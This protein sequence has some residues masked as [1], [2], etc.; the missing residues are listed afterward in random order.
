MNTPQPL[1]QPERGARRYLRLRYFISMPH[2]ALFTLGALQTVLVMLW[3]LA[4]LGGR[5]GGWYTAPQWSVPAPW[6]HLYLMIF[7]VFPLFMFGFLMT[8][9]PKWMAGAPV[10][11]RHYLTAAALLAG[12]IP[13]T[14]IGLLTTKVI[15]LLALAL[16]LAGW[17]LALTALLRVYFGAQRPDT[18][19]TL[20]TSGGLAL[21]LLLLLAYAIGIYLE[22]A[23]W[24]AIAR[25][26]GVWWFLLPVFFAVSHRLIPFFSSVVLPDYP[27][28]RPNWA[29]WLVCAGSLTHGVLELADLSAWT[30]L[31]DLP[32]AATAGYLTWAWLLRQSL[33]ARILAMLHLSFA[34]I[35]IALV[36]YGIHS[37]MLLAGTGYALGRGPLHALLIGYFASLLVA[38]STRVSLG[39]SGRSLTADQMA[40]G[41][42]LSLQAVAVLRAVA[43]FPLVS[44]YAAP[45]YLLS[46]M[47]WLAAFII[48]GIRFLPLYWR[49]ENT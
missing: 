26:G 18:T 40:W 30:W 23:S 45:L 4:D 42:F 8:T 17:A 35:T 34:W 7:L 24:I 1:Q 13:L 39:H 27:L 3:W 25:I 20:V 6:A 38:M 19:H 10:A 29:L 46:A 36:L 44:A 37:L 15:F 32:M 12:A 49:S 16:H 43:D 41:I 48:W 47:L 33:R 31:V 9:Y 5:Y 21:G 14:Y 22:D 28:V 11:P 2:H